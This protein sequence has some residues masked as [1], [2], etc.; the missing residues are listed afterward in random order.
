MREDK[1]NPEYNT[2]SKAMDTILKA[3]PKAV[4]AAM[5]AD[6]QNREETRKAKRKGDKKK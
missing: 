2:F 5:E 1:T 6:K 3:D 4:K